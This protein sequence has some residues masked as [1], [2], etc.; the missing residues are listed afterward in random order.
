MNHCFFKC[1]SNETT[2]D[3]Q[4]ECASK[5]YSNYTLLISADGTINKN[6][7]KR[8]YNT[9]A[10]FE[11]RWMSIINASV[12]ECDFEKSEALSQSLAK[13][14]ECV[15]LRLENNCVSFVNTLECDG[16]QEYYERC[17]NIRYDCDSWPE[18]MIFPISCCKT[19]Q[20]FTKQL[21]YS[22]RRKCLAEEFFIP[23]QVKCIEYCLLN[24]TNIKTDGKFNIDVVKNL[25]IENTRTKPSWQKGIEDATTKCDKK[26][27]GKL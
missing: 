19:P 6:V 20:L 1:N 17:N 3:E 21:T 2:L 5:C 22:C 9:N 11:E 25:L 4:N 23:R 16:V 12:S 10:L 18:D 8:I 13:F 26:M 27:K 14:Y 15:N 7:V 24:E